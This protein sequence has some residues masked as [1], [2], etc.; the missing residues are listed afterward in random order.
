MIYTTCVTETNCPNGGNGKPGG[1][2][3]GMIHLF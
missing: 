1:L 2:V 3:L